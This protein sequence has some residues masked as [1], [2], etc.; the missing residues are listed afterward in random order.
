MARTQNFGMNLGGPH[1]GFTCGA[2]D[3]G[4]E[5]SDVRSSV[6]DSYDS[7]PSSIHK[8]DRDQ[9]SLTSFIRYEAAPCPF[10]RGGPHV[11]FTCGAFDLAGGP[12]VGSTCGAFDFLPMLPQPY[13]TS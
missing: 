9:P 7:H 12:H 3:L 4:F 6:S 13:Q 10:T 11:G 2:F 5:F 8:I 1:V